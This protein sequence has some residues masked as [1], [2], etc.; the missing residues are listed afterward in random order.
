M[1]TVIE[2]GCPNGTDLVVGEARFNPVAKANVVAQQQVR[3]LRI[4]E[5]YA[6]I[7]LSLEPMLADSLTED[8]ER[9]FVAVLSVVGA[10]RAT[11]CR[12]SR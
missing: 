12:L 6:V 1:V 2:G 9:D 7:C 4:G 10:G 5:D 11:S 3:A 8:G